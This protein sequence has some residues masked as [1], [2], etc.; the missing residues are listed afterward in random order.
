MHAKSKGPKFPI[1]MRFF[2]FQSQLQVIED[3]QLKLR[4]PIYRYLKSDLETYERA[5][6]I[7]TNRFPV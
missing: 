4:R 1:T 5:M 3:E 7:P 2:P 6:L